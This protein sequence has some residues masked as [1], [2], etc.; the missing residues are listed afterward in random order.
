MCFKDKIRQIL[1]DHARGLFDIE[2]NK[3]IA[4]VQMQCWID[5]DATADKVV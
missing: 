2:I 5:W 4:I 1:P 3:H